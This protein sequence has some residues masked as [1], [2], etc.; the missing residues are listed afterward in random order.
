MMDN[1]PFPRWEFVTDGC[2]R[3]GDKGYDY[4]IDKDR[5]I[6]QVKYDGSARKWRCATSDT[7]RAQIVSG[8]GDLFDTREQAMEAAEDRCNRVAE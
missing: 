8:T 7:I 4:Y 5:Y 6:A 2:G 1:R 3:S